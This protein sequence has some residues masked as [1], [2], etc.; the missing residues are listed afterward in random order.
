MVCSVGSSQERNGIEEQMCRNRTQNP[1]ECQ[2]L[3]LRGP[4]EQSQRPDDGPPET[5]G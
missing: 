5:G 4:K 1:R 3:S 2:R